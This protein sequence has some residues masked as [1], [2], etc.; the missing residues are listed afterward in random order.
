MVRPETRPNCGN[1]GPMSDHLS[2]AVRE[3]LRARLLEER[4]RLLRRVGIEVRPDE[5]PDPSDLQDAAA[6]ETRVNAM[7]ALSDRDRAHLR[8]VEAALLRMHDGTYGE[9]EETGEPIPVAR[10]RIEPTTRYTVE[11]LEILEDEGRRAKIREADE[12]DEIY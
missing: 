6:D 5:M 4:H 7:L 3:E 2:D 9:C 12:S 10:L 8:E 1:L 11:A